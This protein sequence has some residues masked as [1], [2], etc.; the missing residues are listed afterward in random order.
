MQF[1]R[2]VLFLGMSGVLRRQG[3]G[4]KIWQSVQAL[5][6]RRLDSRA[7]GITNLLSI[8]E[9]SQR[10]YAFGLRGTEV[11]RLSDW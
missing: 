8:G 1:C 4:R 9:D 6:S 2:S 3:G 7:V 10:T 5:S 11:G